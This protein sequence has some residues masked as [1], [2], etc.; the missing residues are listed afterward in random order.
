[1]AQYFKYVYSVI[2]VIVDS[3]PANTGAQQF[4]LFQL[5]LRQSH[6]GFSLKTPF[7]SENSV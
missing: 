7:F 1:M 4:D 5:A 3:L 6:Y 2:S